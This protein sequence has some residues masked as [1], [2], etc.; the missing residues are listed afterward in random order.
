MTSHNCLCY[1]LGLQSITKFR[2]TK[3]KK[4]F[5]I[6]LSELLIKSNAASFYF[7]IAFFFFGKKRRKLSTLRSG[8][9]SQKRSHRTGTQKEKNK[10][11]A[12]RLRSDKRLTYPK[13]ITI[14]SILIRKSWLL[15]PMIINKTTRPCQVFKTEPSARFRSSIFCN[16]MILVWFQ[17]TDQTTTH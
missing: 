17:Q 12:C 3:R 13:L 10:G 6:F 7:L 15:F 11:W 5:Y 9:E 14:K 8:W 1:V 4:K 16:Y 2:E